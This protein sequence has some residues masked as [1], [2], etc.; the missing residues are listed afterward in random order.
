M[1]LLLRPFAMG[2]GGS[3]LY[4]SSGFCASLRVEPAA[5]TPSPPTLSAATLALV[6]SA[7]LFGIAILGVANTARGRGGIKWLSH[8]WERAMW[9]SF[10][11]STAVLAVSRPASL[12]ALVIQG[13]ESAEE[14]S[15]SPQLADVA[16]TATRVG[17]VTAGA[18]LMCAIVGE[19]LGSLFGCALAG[20][21]LLGS[22][23][24]AVLLPSEPIET[25]ALGP[26]VLIPF[27]LL[28][29]PPVFTRSLEL[30]TVS[31]LALTAF[32]PAIVERISAKPPDAV[33]E[34]LLVPRLAF[35]QI[36]CAMAL[37]GLQI[38]LHRRRPICQY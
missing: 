18:S 19:R 37:A 4:A 13:S 38:Y 6:G 7:P 12:L 2:L 26:A 33:A 11:A 3:A 23:T 27:L 29:S 28:A 32:V 20:P 1:K 17:M 24:A 22:I 10:F 21:V 30:G 34:K 25:F 5:P 15:G 14:A 8:Y 9:S 36:M 31:I 16:A 35:E